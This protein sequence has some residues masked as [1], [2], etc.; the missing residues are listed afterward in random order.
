M[1]NTKNYIIGAIL[2]ILI[3]YSVRYFNTVNIMKQDND[4]KIVLTFKGESQNW[5]GLFTQE[6]LKIWDNKTP[7]EDRFILKYI[8]PDVKNVGDVN[9]SYKSNAGGGGGT[10][11]LDN[12]GTAS[13]GGRGIGSTVSK[14]SVITVTVEWNETQETF[15]MVVQ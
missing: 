15:R 3:T 14:E 4:K 11:P 9:F 13:S 2:L 12:N 8:G 10:G 6:T 7:L 1:V 5:E